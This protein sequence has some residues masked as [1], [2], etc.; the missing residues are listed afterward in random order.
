MP[1]PESRLSVPQSSRLLHRSGDTVRRQVFGAIQGRSGHT[2]VE[3]AEKV[4]T[5]GPSVAREGGDG[6]TR[7]LASRE[8]LRGTLAGLG[9]DAGKCRQR[10]QEG[11]KKSSHRLIV[12]GSQCTQRCAVEHDLLAFG[13]SLQLLSLVDCYVGLAQQRA[14]RVALERRDH[15][16]RPAH[17]VGGLGVGS[18]PQQRHRVVERSVLGRRK[19]KVVC[20]YPACWPQLLGS[21]QANATPQINTMPPRAPRTGKNYP[22]CRVWRSGIATIRDG[23]AQG[24]EAGELAFRQNYNHLGIVNL[25]AFRHGPKTRQIVKCEAHPRH[26]AMQPI[27]GTIRDRRL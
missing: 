15:Q 26:A 10:Q 14:R 21:I 23:P 16:C 22:L 9:A 19:K 17:E 24:G 3:D 8:L 12:A 11:R 13:H 4:R 25:I 18:F 6:D 7:H 2:A 5:Q 27:G 1:A 20:R